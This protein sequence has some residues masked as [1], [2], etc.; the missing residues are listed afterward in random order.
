MTNA[1]VQTSSRAFIVQ[2]RDK[3]IEGDAAL[4]VLLWVTG[5]FD[6]ML[7]PLA[8]VQTPLEGFFD[9]DDLQWISRRLQVGINNRELVSDTY[10]PADRFAELFHGE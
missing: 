4:I 8:L 10:I 9:K 3:A 2:R 1:T 7:C 6:A 5:N